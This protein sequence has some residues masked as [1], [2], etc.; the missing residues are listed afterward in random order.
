LRRHLVFV[1][2]AFPPP[3]VYVPAKRGSEPE[4]F[5]RH[6]FS[7]ADQAFERHPFL[8]GRIGKVCR[9]TLASLSAAA[10]GVSGNRQPLCRLPSGL[11]AFPPRDPPLLAP[12][13]NPLRFATGR[14]KYTVA[15]TLSRGIFSKAFPFCTRVK[16]RSPVENISVENPPRTRLTKEAAQ[17]IFRI[18]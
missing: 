2:V 13:A 8:S 4:G 6:C 10:R 15:R 5:E 3:P 1:V 7:K 18:A 11:S 9:L 16:K 12:V 14:G 17:V